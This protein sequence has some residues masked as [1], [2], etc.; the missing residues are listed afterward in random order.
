WERLLDFNGYCPALAYQSSDSG[1]ESCTRAGLQLTS[2][3]LAPGHV[4]RINYT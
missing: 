4:G 1:I 2:V 3:I